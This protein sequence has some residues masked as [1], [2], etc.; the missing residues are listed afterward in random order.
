M[1]FERSEIA[2]QRQGELLGTISLAEVR[3]RVWD[4]VILGGGVAGSSAAILAA[5]AG[6]SVL[7]IEAKSFPR[8]KVCGGCLNQRAQSFLKKIG[9][10]D[11]LLSAGAIKLDEFHVRYDNVG[12]TWS[13]PPLLSV[14]R[15]TLDTLL[16]RRAIASGAAFLPNTTGY[17]LQSRDW[18][19]SQEPIGINTIR[20]RLKSKCAFGDGSPASRNDTIFIDEKTVETIGESK[21]VLVAA[22]LNRSPLI[23]KERESEWPEVVATNS[24]IGVQALVDRTSFQRYA[25]RTSFFSDS[26]NRLTMLAS[27]EGYVGIC[28]TDGGMVDMAAAIEASSIGGK[29]GIPKAISRIAE[30]CGLKLG[31]DILQATWLATPFLTR[32]SQVVAKPGVF[33]VGDS[34]GYVEPFTGEGMSWAFSNSESVVPIIKKAIETGDY[35][36]AQKDWDSAVNRERRFRQ[37]VC[38]WIAKQARF[39]YRSQ[40]VLRACHWCAPFRNQLLRKAVQ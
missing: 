7:I 23:G 14:R 18:S 3:R 4:V 5:T 11:V 33:L 8:E 24:R 38:K 37:S 13:I 19:A 28:D 10:W 31:E 1:S 12:Y 29:G 17:L 39:R 27:R 34:L 2:Q 25:S 40:W 36:G 20:I 26:S 9:V 6:L 15:S 32:T 35:R 16:I 21:C 22:G 30:K